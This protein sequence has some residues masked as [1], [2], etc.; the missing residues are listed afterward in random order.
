MY[1]VSVFPLAACSISENRMSRGG[2]SAYM[3]SR[4]RLPNSQSP[5]L[6]TFGK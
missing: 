3:I 4:I 1:A 6:C 5:D 2:P